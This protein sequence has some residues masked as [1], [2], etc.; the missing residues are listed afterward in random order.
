MDD[1]K[2]FTKYYFQFIWQSVI[3]PICMI[4]HAVKW[5]LSVLGA[6]L[7]GN[8]GGGNEGSKGGGF[9][10]GVKADLQNIRIQKLGDQ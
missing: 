4:W 3:M 1:L 7:S 9:W 8:G 10:D 6:M 2:W 5:L